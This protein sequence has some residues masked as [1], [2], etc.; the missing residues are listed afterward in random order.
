MQ[1]LI[2]T[3]SIVQYPTEK[4]FIDP[5]IR[6]NQKPKIQYQSTSYFF[7][8]YPIEKPVY[9]PVPENQ[10]LTQQS[11]RKLKTRKSNIQIE[12]LKPQSEDS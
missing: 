10:I 4:L 6:E 7:R 5:N 3:K 8:P 12:K 2:D 1:K 9:N 11:Y